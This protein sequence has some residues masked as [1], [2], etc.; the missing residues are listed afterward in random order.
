M[1]LH[2]SRPNEKSNELKLSFF[3]IQQPQL[4][5]RKIYSFEIGIQSFFVVLYA[6]KE[7][8]RKVIFA[9]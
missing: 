8:F 5:M 2:S 4:S 7:F 1:A 6:V 3:I 9:S